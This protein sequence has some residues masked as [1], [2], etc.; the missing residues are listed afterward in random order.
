MANMPERGDVGPNPCGVCGHTKLWCGSR[1]LCNPCQA[2]RNRDRKARITDE[3]REAER[4]RA[5]EMRNARR[6]TWTPERRAEAN[7]Y[8][9]Q[10]RVENPDK[11]AAGKR[12]YYARRAEQ[13]KAA[14]AAEYRAN[15]AKFVARA[16]KRK[17][18][19]LEAVC[20]HGPQC[21]SATFLADLYAS[22]CAYCDG[23]SEEADHFHPLSRGGLHCR[24]N[25]VPACFPCNRSKYN[26]E[27]HKWMASRVA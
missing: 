8:V 24:D 2:K 16:M 3:Q 11:H 5:N 12:S 23:P 27:P 17:A 21:V 9:A 6:A 25:L 1:F 26:H 19:L 18:L 15:P 7:A 4:L 14:K 22:T 20:E 10:W 13:I